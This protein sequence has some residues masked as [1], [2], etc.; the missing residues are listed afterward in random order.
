[1]IDFDHN[2]TTVIAPEALEAMCV[3]ARECPGNPGSRHAAGRKARLALDES[4]EQIAAL[5]GAK[6]SE[7][8]FTSGGTESNNSAIRGYCE[9]RSGWIALPDGEHPS[10]EMPVRRLESLGWGRHT[11]ALDAHGLIDPAAVD[12]IPWGQI[13]LVTCLLAH[14]ETGVIRDLNVLAQRCAAERVPLHVD[15]VQAVGK[16]EVNFRELGATS[17]SV[18][19][20]KFHGPRG[21]GALLIREGVRLPSLLL[22]GHQE[23][24]RRAGTE[25][26]ALA[27]GMARALRVWFEKR[28]RWTRAVSDLRDRLEQQLRDRCSPVI[29]HSAGA[30]RL[31]NTMNVAFPGCDGEALLV[32]LDLAGIGCSLGSACASGA[33][34]PPAILRAM[35]CSLEE[36]RCSI[37]LSLGRDNTDAEIALAVSRIATIVHRMRERRA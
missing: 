6:A 10:I 28:D 24:E 35:G 21:I 9:G 27:V 23:R 22:G 33:S 34:E 13:R 14:N 29:V 15:A 18:A 11:V 30:S 36:A 8:I 20:H 19:A 16:I 2:A 31:P 12:A 32:A 26:V 37:R 1:M 4:R 5:L 25:P 7:V 3:A 17:M